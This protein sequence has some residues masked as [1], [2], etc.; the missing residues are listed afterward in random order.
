MSKTHDHVFSERED[1]L[2]NILGKRYFF[3]SVFMQKK[4]KEKFFRQ[5]SQNFSFSCIIHIFPRLLIFI[6]YYLDCFSLA[7]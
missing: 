6:C 3:I 2:L 1:F 4:K 5:F 7:K